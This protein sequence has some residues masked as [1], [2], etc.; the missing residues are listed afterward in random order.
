MGMNT[1]K[2]TFLTVSLIILFSIAGSLSA[3]VLEEII[4]TAEKREASI[5]DTAISITVYNGE[6]LESL[7]IRELQSLSAQTPSM[8][9][10]RAGGEAQIYLRGVGNNT[11]GIGVDPSVALH[12]D[13]VYLGRAQMGLGQFMDIE[14]VEVLR[15]PQGTL[16]GRNATG[17]AINMITRGPTSEW[18]GYA[19]GYYGNF[20]RKQGEV[21]IGGPISDSAGIRL[22]VRGIEDDGFTDD[23]DPAGG[24]DID[25]QQSISGRG[26]IEFTPSDDVTFR[27]QADW[28]EFDSHNRTIRPLDDTGIAQT[29]GALPLADFDE[30][31]NSIPSFLDYE[32][33]G[34]TA[35]LEWMITENIQLTSVTG[36]REF[37]DSFRFNTDGT[38]IDVT[39]THFERDTN[40]VSEEIRLAS[41][42][43]ERWEW[44]LGYYYYNEEKEEA[45]GLPNRKFAAFAGP[46]TPNSFNLFG[47]NETE[48]H[49]VFGQLAYS[50][51]E[52]VKLTLGG[53]Y[54]YEKKD[55]TGS[56]T[57]RLNFDGL[58]NPANL[59]NPGL[60][61]TRTDS[62]NAFTPKVGLDYR[63]SDDV[64]LYFTASR[65]FKSGGTNSLSTSPLGFDPE[66]I[67][68]YEGGI[69]SEWSKLRVN[70]TAFYY[71]YSDLQV[72]TFIDGTVR[73]DNAAS[74]EIMGGEIDL[75]AA[76]NEQLTWRLSVS[77]LDT[78]YK[79][80]ISAFGSNASGPI[81][82]DL[83]G[84]EL[85]NA[86]DFKLSTN[87]NYNHPLAN[88]AALAFTGQVSYQSKVFYS[89]ENESLMSQEGYAL[90]DARLAYV[91]PDGKWEIAGVTRN[92]FDEE[93]FQNTV[94]FTSM[95]DV[96]RDPNNF[97]HPLGY[98]GEGRSFGVQAS[99]RF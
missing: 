45:L 34:I 5:Q 67:W 78:E 18:E 49:A 11:F 64:L 58:L 81:V 54:S 48:A 65:G 61:R 15:G 98:P 32:T 40:Q 66:F 89:K 85:I 30:T 50:M 43:L 28:T 82:S 99:Y 41:V 13:N 83:S 60:R 57:F 96:A 72:S 6:D 86:P 46:F 71:D 93:Y 59:A 91:S 35:T 97:G 25:D 21:A 14:R 47:E 3:A 88:G 94:R 92:L 73:I 55:D 2:R 56:F 42:G 95:N 84:N 29:L 27:F 87:V 79:D 37:E 23:L 22:A 70:A 51:T 52:N 7:E 33:G 39:E 19:R 17:G 9:F 76:I 20:D 69:K 12:L 63:Y 4:V 24:K 44:L 80:F 1:P 16:Y 62:W 8:A 77:I 26:I 10:S 90:V 38:E 68:S 53:R 31:R 75:A 74:A 36:Y